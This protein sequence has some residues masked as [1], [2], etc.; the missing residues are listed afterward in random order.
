MKKYL[1]LLT[2]LIGVILSIT[3]ISAQQSLSAQPWGDNDNHEVWHSGQDV[4]VKIGEDYFSLQNIIDNKMDN[5]SLWFQGEHNVSHH[6][7]NIKV[8]IG[9]R[10]F[11]LQR[12]ISHSLQFLT[13]VLPSSLNQ[14]VDKNFVIKEANAQNWKKICT[15]SENYTIG[16]RY[17]LYMR[18]ITAEGFGENISYNVKCKYE[19][20]NADQK[21]IKF[22]GDYQLIAQGKESH[23][24]WAGFTG[25]R[26]KSLFGKDDTF[27]YYLNLQ[28]GEFKV[29]VTMNNGDECPVYKAKKGFGLRSETIYQFGSVSCTING[30][31]SCTK[32]FSTCSDGTNVSRNESL[33]C[34]FSP[35]PEE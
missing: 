31:F 29:K 24:K 35:C 3:F 22:N 21:T 28:N 13:G 32:E 15:T 8:K 1:F 20:N 14:T 2:V 34:E 30:Q 7:S 4:Q 17:A 33:N 18:P 27:K 19:D 5:D 25:S 16:D 9:D 12:V 26:D 23:I 6:A 11:S 10:Y